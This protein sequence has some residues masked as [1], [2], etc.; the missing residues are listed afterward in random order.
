MKKFV[1]L[2]AGTSGLI[3][4]TMIKKRWKDQV[5]VSVY[6]DSNQKNIGVGESTTPIIDMF[7]KK[8]LEVP[9]DKLIRETSTTVKLGISFKNWIEGVEYFHGFPEIDFTVDDYSSSTYSL[10]NGTY[11]GGILHS[12]ATDLVPSYFFRYIHALHIDTQE[13]SKYVQ[14]KIEGEVE[15]IDDIAKE[16]K[17]DGKNIQSIVFE[18][19]GEVTA[20]FYIDASGFNS[21]LL[22]TLNPKWNDIL[23]MLPMDRAIPQQVP[24]QFNEIPSYTVAEARKHG[25]IWKIPIGDR[26]GTGYVYSSKFTSDEE[27]REDYNLWLNDTFGVQLNTDRVIHYKPG[28]YEN[29][30][31]GNCMA[32]G[33]S[34]GFVEPL[35]STGIHIIIQQMMNF[36]DYNPTL[37]NLEY[38]KQESNRLNRTLYSE[39]VEFICLH[40]NTNRED[41]KFWKY[42]TNNK[43]EWV[44]NFDE[45]C[46]EEF[47][48]KS[49]ITSSKVFWNI[50]SYIQVANGLQMFNQDSIQNYVNSLPNSNQILEECKLMD[51]EI[52]KAK[53]MNSNVPQKD[54]IKF[55]NQ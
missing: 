29:N 37:K 50:E 20:D 53:N 2:G 30:W 24:Y 15:F 47:L 27:A 25:W 3:A 54:M 9:I 4:A 40:Y 28:Y 41:S 22:E 17:S 33:L 12:K 16:I 34:S 10:L 44:R 49:S 19:S 18:N 48:E 6:Y 14:K 7:L 8:Y 31:I 32:V 52:K 43:T 42:M 39:I 35:E 5:H 13:F 36:I 21:I 23:E 46:R 1:I 11:D 26:F 45:K 51:M 55:V 38:N